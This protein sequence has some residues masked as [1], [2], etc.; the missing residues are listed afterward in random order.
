M[1]SSR[2]NLA[3]YEA[4]YKDLQT[5]NFDPISGNIIAGNAAKARVRGSEIEVEMLPIDWLTLG[6]SYSYTDAK[7]RSYLVPNAPPAPPTDNAGHTIPFTPNNT[8]NSEKRRD[9]A[10]RTREPDSQ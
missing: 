9:E 8:S 3:V 5:R 7:Y 6:L 4:E 1:D 10:C 2:F